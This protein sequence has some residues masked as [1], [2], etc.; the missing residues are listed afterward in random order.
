MPVS[1]SRS[2]KI[3][4][5]CTGNRCRSPVA[6]GFLARASRGLPVEVSSAGLLD[7]GPAPALPEVVKAA[8]E[9]GLA[10]TDHRARSLDK[11]SLDGFDLVIGLERSHVAVAVVERGV[12]FERAFTLGELVRLLGEVGPPSSE[13]DLVARARAAV[14]RAHEARK[15]ARFVP[16]EDV[17]DP[18]GGPQEGYVKMVRDLDRLCSSLAAG[19]FGE[20]AAKVAM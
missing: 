20:A 9:L 2:F 14:A 15:T 10:V 6:Q 12:P 16:G 11:L 18:F 5:L 19:L 8:G 7:L 13:P 3:L 17:S 1:E 4:F